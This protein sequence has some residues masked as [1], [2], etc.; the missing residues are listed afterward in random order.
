[1][2]LNNSILKLSKISNLII[3]FFGEHYPPNVWISYT[4]IP[5]MMRSALADPHHCTLIDE[6]SIKVD[7]ILV[8]YCV[9]MQRAIS[10][11]L[12]GFVIY[13]KYY[14]GSSVS[15]PLTLLCKCDTPIFF[16][17]EMQGGQ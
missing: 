9:E 2:F 4:P 6:I 7:R 3:T 11:A 17:V 12:L 15:N 1:M 5:L 8:D 13:I 10:Q 14:G 16:K